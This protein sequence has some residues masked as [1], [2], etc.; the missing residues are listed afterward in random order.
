MIPVRFS[1]ASFS[2]YR[3]QTP[4]QTDAYA[5]VQAWM[6][7]VGDGPMLA[8]V[9][10]QGT[11]KSHLLYSAARALR[12]IVD[13]MDAKVRAQTGAQHP[14]VAPWYTLADQL[15]YGMAVETPGGSRQR[16]AHEVRANLWS[17]R[18][19]L[20][21][22]VRPT[23]STS[24]DDSEL[25]KFACHAYDNRMAVLITTNV[26]PLQDVMGPAAASRFLQI[27]IDG[28]DARQAA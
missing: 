27:V 20:L 6:S 26:N 14:F 10:R 17:R 18:I 21:D 1:H 12:D 25:A 5:A 4:S 8:L 28:P 9:G 2:T 15:R 13:G 16:D 7:A 11:G 24:F 23:S 19:V 3:Q 22:E